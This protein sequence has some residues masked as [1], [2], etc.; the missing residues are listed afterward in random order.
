ML[1]AIFNWIRN[2]G[3]WP[4]MALTVSLGFVV[5][6][7]AVSALGERALQDSTERIT[8]ERLAIARMT[9]RQLDMLFEQAVSELEHTHHLADF[10]PSGP[11][12]LLEQDILENTYSEDRLFAPGIIFLDAEGRVVVSAP[13]SLYRPGTDLSGEAHI[14]QA[15]S[16]SAVTLSEPFREP[17][18]QRPVVAVTV[19]IHNREGRLLGLLS[20]LVHLTGPAIMDTLQQATALG[21]TGHA[22]LTD[23]RGRALASTSHP[24][25]PF[26]AFGEHPTFYRQ[27]MATA[28]PTVGTVPFEITGVPDEP[29]G[30]LH[31]MAFAP[32]KNAPWG[33]AVGGDEDETFAGVWRLRSGLIAIGLAAFIAVLVVTLVS[34]RRLLLPIQQLT[35]AAHRIAEGNLN[36]PLR[37]SRRD[38]IG[39][40]AAALEAMRIQ[41]M[42]NIEKLANWN[43]A[44]EELV[45]RQTDELHQQQSVLSGLDTAIRTPL[46]LREILEQILTQTRQAGRV[47]QGAIYLYNEEEDNIYP[48]TFQ[49]MRLEQVNQ[50]RGHAFRSIAGRQTLLTPQE[51]VSVLAVPMVCMDNM[52]VGAFLLADP[53]PEVFSQR[54]VTLLSAI[55]S[56]T[57]LVIRNN[58]LYSRLES[59]TILEERSRL[60]REIHDGLVQ[61]L[62]YLKLQVN[63]MQR[64]IRE[65]ELARLETE[66]GHL[67]EVLEEAYADAR[68]AIVGLRVGLNPGDT[69]E[70]ILAEYVQSF[71]ARYHLP[72]DMQVKGHNPNIQPVIILQLTRIAQEGL[73]NIRKHAGAT[74]AWVHLYYRPGRMEL[75]I[76][77]N[78]R[79]IDLSRQAGQDP[80]GLQFMRERV[81]S[82]GGSFNIYPRPG[83]GTALLVSVPTPDW[84]EPDPGET[85]AGAGLDEDSA[86]VSAAAKSGTSI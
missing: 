61:T 63:R 72:V 67:G 28:A 14:G 64:W 46:E 6:F 53:R 11:D 27:A 42:G 48:V 19:P 56:Q 39:I 82:L 32:L 58:Q 21:Q 38:E 37:V 25:V 54:Q 5:L 65:G 66:M 33:V 7:A 52:V 60:A 43:E 18:Q 80:G 71:S 49:G 29:A 77:D 75:T 4:Q 23:S 78:G 13:P 84:V 74:R 62:G 69:L 26:M 81:D 70:S 79:G 17:V 35:T 47:A 73:T 8:G 59:Q 20:G 12:L 50:L 2:R 30:H 83:G 22:T 34:A 10:D 76:S 31:V 68:D 24:P 40:M 44:L 55:A 1:P 85:G 15:L 16:G 45:A 36:T 3:L 41:L 51:P 86:A 57:A 9:A